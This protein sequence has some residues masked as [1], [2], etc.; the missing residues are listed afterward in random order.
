MFTNKDYDE[1]V[2]YTEKLRKDP[3]FLQA[4]E[5][6]YYGHEKKILRH[7]LMLGTSLLIVCALSIFGIIKLDGVYVTDISLLEKFLIIIAPVSF[8]IGL[9]FVIS[10]FTGPDTPGE[11][12]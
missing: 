10:F 1:L 12:I 5:E 2:R 11:S 7:Q 9:F 6:R 4:E 8:I 3:L